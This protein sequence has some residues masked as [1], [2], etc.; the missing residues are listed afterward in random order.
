MADSYNINAGADSGVHVNQNILDRFSEDS[1]GNLTFDGEVVN[2]TTA[3]YIRF[4]DGTV[5]QFSSVDNGDGTYGIQAE[6][7]S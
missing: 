3:P 7:I 2:I 4:I 5:W 1:S 6:R